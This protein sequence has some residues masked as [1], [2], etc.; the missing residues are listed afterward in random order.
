MWKFIKPNSSTMRECCRLSKIWIVSMAFF[1][2]KEWQAA[3][4]SAKIGAN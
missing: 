4:W 3:G 1:L 2:L